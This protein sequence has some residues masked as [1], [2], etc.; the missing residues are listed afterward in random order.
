MSL[1]LVSPSWTRRRIL[2]KFAVVLNPWS[3]AHF[4]CCSS[5][6]LFVNGLHCWVDPAEQP[7]AGGVGRLVT[8]MSD[9]EKWY[10]RNL[11]L[12]IG[13]YFMTL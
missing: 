2:H 7:I 10:Y 11:D 12:D 8:A 13:F 4:V 3:L 1:T 6:R 9:S 5:T